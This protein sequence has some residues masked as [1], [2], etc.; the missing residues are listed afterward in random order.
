MTLSPKALAFVG[1]VG[2]LPW[3]LAA[4]PRQ[5]LSQKIYRQRLTAPGASTEGSQRLRQGS[6]VSA[7]IAPGGLPAGPGGAFCAGSEP[8]SD[9][10]TTERA[11]LT[12]ALGRLVSRQRRP[13][14]A[15]MQIDAK[16]LKEDCATA[17]TALAGSGGAHRSTGATAIIE[18]ILPLIR[19]FR[20][21]K[22]GWAAIAA[23][24]A[25]QGVTQGSD[26][27]PISARRLTALISAINKRVQLREARLA[28]RANRGDL[29]PLPANSHGLSL[30]TDLQRTD[31]ATAIASDSEE[32]IRHQEFEDRVRSLLKK[33]PI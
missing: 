12:G 2:L 8:Q 10:G 29:A 13:H 28:G 16:R 1:L 30:S 6:R 15:V 23:A 17:Q 24:L 11:T 26:R 7:P 25:A 22:Y 19:E 14:V 9:L 33:D 27:R 18:P 20:A 4:T 3:G 21:Q 31:F 32:T 5:R